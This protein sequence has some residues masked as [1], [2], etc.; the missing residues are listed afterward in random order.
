MQIKMFNYKGEETQFLWMIHS[1]V[2]EGARIVND[3]IVS[4]KLTDT[5]C[6]AVFQLLPE[7]ESGEKTYAYKDVRIEISECESCE[8]RK[9]FLRPQ[10]TNRRSLSDEVLQIYLVVYFKNSNGSLKVRI[11]KKPPLFPKR[12]ETDCTELGFKILHI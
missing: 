9:M 10:T 12:I 2:F 11:L 5:G 3:R 7:L 8:I 1:E 4:K 6:L